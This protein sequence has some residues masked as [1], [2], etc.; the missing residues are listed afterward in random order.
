MLVHISNADAFIIPAAWCK[1]LRVKPAGGVVYAMF[2]AIKVAFF[3]TEDV[4]FSELVASPAAFFGSY[5]GQENR[6][7]SVCFLGFDKEGGQG[8]LVM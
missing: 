5:S 8:Y 6:V 7:Y 4:V 3:K 1:V 2:Q